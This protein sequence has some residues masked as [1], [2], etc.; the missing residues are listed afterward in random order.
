MR[1]KSSTPVVLRAIEEGDM[2]EWGNRVI[3][4]IGCVGEGG[5]RR[6][7]GGSV[8]VEPPAKRALESFHFAPKGEV[9]VWHR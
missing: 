2:S 3:A 8:A 1:E 9:V 7:G 4:S 5:L 6:D